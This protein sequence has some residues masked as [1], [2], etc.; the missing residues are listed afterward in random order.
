MKR[1]GCRVL[2]GESEGRR[3]HMQDGGV[4]KMYLK[5]IGRVVD[6]IGPAQSRV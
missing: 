5:E 2:I 6:W 3:D 1:Y 4:M